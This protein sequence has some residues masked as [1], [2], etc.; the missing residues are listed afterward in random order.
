M[1]PFQLLIKPA[2]FNCNL[3]C[4][5]CFYL[6]VEDLYSKNTHLRMS[7][8]VL[9]KMIS[10]Y[11]KFR[12]NE[13]VFN[14]QGGE[15][16]LCG[17]DFFK[18]AVE[19]QQQYGISGQVVGNGFQTNGILINDDW[20]KFLSEYRFLIGLSIDGPKQI[21]DR[22]RRSLG[23]KSVWEKVMNTAKCL[24]DNGVEFNILCVV[25]KANVNRVKEVYKFFLDNGF[26]YLQF[27]PALEVD[28][29]GKKAS[30]C[31]NASQFG[32]FLCELYDE[33]MESG[34]QA[35][36]RIFDG[37]FAH[38]LGHPKGYCTLEE[39]CSNYI[40]VEWNGDIYPCDF[41]VYENYKLGNILNTSFEEIINKRNET[42]VPLKGKL[43][44]EC[45]SCDW[46]ELCY[47]GC[48]KDRFFQDNPHPEKTYLCESYK[49]IFSQSN[50]WFKEQARLFSI[51]K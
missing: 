40:V 33:W 2:S 37:I 41:F 35:S 43:S 51:R 50:D 26:H 19:L 16:T 49:K 10:E 46:K 7:N 34:Q 6:R 30:F 20:A 42:F 29:T 15:P 3:R 22:Y 25:S 1:Q 44:G 17:L 12:F 21:H 23:S 32:K 24:R 39:N 13:S 14:W 31:I 28:E 45:L 27:I 4:T 8:E 47:G 5:Y 38:H 18:R 36:I 9:E 11:L 48:L